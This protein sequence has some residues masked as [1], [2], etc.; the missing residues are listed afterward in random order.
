M[1]V[2]AAVHDCALR[3]PSDKSLKLPLERMLEPLDTLPHIITGKSREQSSEK[4]SKLGPLWLCYGVPAR[5]RLVVSTIQ[6]TTGK[7]SRAQRR[8][9]QRGPSSRLIQS[10]LPPL[11]GPAAFRKS[12]S[13]APAVKAASD[14]AVPTHRKR[15]D[16]SIVET[17]WFHAFGSAL[18]PL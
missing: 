8:N 11:E 7:R 3:K 17:K 10:T 18:S 1:E 16:A 15:A 2:E 6:E 9:H 12:L 5:N 4:D 13:D 14:V